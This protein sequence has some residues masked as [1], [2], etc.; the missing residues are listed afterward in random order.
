MLREH[1]LLKNNHNFHL[2][3]FQSK[4]SGSWESHINSILKKQ[5]TFFN[6]HA[7]DILSAD[8]SFTQDSFL[9]SH[10]L[11]QFF[12]SLCSPPPKLV[13][14]VIITKASLSLRLDNDMQLWKTQKLGATIKPTGSHD[15]CTFN[16]DII[17]LFVEKVARQKL[18]PAPVTYA[19]R[20]RTFSILWCH[21]ECHYPHVF[22]GVSR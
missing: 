19:V 21:F 10:A 8:G 7:A 9:A 3:A 6:W 16:S 18:Y 22:Q 20:H 17:L 5:T 4:V 2:F 15:E 14:G 12:M 11:D 1:K 13:T